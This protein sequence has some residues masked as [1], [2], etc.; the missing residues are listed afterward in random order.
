M[1]RVW[2]AG[3]GRCAH[4]SEGWQAWGA[5][6]V[7]RS[8]TEIAMGTEGAQ[9]T[10]KVGGRSDRGYKGEQRTEEEKT[11]EIQNVSKTHKV[12][13]VNVVWEVQEPFKSQMVKEPLKLHKIKI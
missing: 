11:Y 5:Q 13:D 6:E 1:V 8:V 2:E 7:T 9:E 3:V 12:Q 10:R 4:H